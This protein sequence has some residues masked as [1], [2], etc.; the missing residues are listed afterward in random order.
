M[1]QASDIVKVICA[2]LVSR[3]VITIDDAISIQA[4][5]AKL[6]GMDTTEMSMTE[7]IE[8]VHATR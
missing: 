5:A 8:K 7:I 1:L 3:E 4:K 6:A 2:L